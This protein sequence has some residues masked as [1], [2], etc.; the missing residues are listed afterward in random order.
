MEEKACQATQEELRE[1]N[2]R[3]WS[4]PCKKTAWFQDWGGWNW[5]V[6]H[7]WREIVTN[8]TWGNMWFEIRK[9]KVRWPFN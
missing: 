6:K 9:M 7:T 8:E 2:R 3:C 4:P 1:S 5:C